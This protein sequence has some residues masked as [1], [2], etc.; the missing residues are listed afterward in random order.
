MMFQYVLNCKILKSLVPHLLVSI[1]KFVNIIT[2]IMLG[3]SVKDGYCN[4]T[5]HKFSDAYN[6][7]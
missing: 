4:P 1:V 6:V 3:L 7:V 2:Y 5:K